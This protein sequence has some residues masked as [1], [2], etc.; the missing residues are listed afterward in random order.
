[1]I[2]H[3]LCRVWCCDLFSK[4]Y[5]FMMGDMENNPYKI[6][7]VTFF[8]LNIVSLSNTRDVGQFFWPGDQKV[9][10]DRGEQFLFPQRWTKV[11]AK[12]FLHV[13]ILTFPF[14]FACKLVICNEKFHFSWFII[15]LL[16]GWRRLHLHVRLCN[17]RTLLRRLIKMENNQTFWPKNPIERLF[18]KLVS[19][20]WNA[21]L[22]P[23]KQC[24]HPRYFMQ[25]ECDFQF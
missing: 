22:S 17:R 16:Q 7:Q 1:M 11:S 24:Q 2:N 19:S 14:H 8:W 15:T 12:F 25:N 9:Q 5:D 4:K 23:R 3:F 10:D 20:N 21:K 6:A 18:A 13:R